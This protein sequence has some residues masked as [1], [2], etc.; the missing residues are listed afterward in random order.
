MISRLSLLRRSM[1]PASIRLMSGKTNGGAHVRN[2]AD[3]GPTSGQSSAPIE[4]NNED[5]GG[6]KP[7]SEQSNNPQQQKKK[8]NEVKQSG[9]VPHT[10]DSTPVSKEELNRKMSATE[11]NK[12]EH[13]KM[14][15]QKEYTEHELGSASENIVAAERS[16]QDPLP[17]EAKA[18]HKKH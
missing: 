9:K 3:Y 14:R 10:S 2:V 5:N 11:G 1:R 4:E 7:K 8:A 12:T 13:E 16:G 17:D 15:N 6:N 18:S